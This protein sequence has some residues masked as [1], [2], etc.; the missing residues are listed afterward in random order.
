MTNIQS[1][2]ERIH[3][4]NLGQT[5]ALLL[6]FF[7]LTY[8]VYSAD[9]EPIS[10]PE[11]VSVGLYLIDVYDISFPENQIKLDFYMWFRYRGE[12]NNPLSTVE[13]VN[14]KEV[15]ISGET[16]EPYTDTQYRS[17][18]LKVVLKKQWNVRAF[19]FDRHVIHLYVED[20]ENEASSLVYI[21]DLRYSK[22]D[23][24]IDIPGWKLSEFSIA[25]RPHIWQTTYGDPSLGDSEYADYSRLTCSFV[26]SRKDRGLSMF[27][28][29]FMGLF[30]AIGISFLTFT[31]HPK[32]VDPRF[33]LSVGAI[34]AS[35]TNLYVVND[36]LPETTNITFVGSAHLI[37][38]AFILACITISARSLYL[39]NA[40]K[41]DEYRSLDRMSLIF[42]P[43][44]YISLMV[45]MFVAMVLL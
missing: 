24:D 21:P 44:A 18:K 27:L 13:I 9:D 37:T 33:G 26:L 34:F 28:N 42:L 20:D 2:N 43:I 12:Q 10:P 4:S 40:G 30:L 45:V 25:C 23:P 16:N 14:S 41:V 31:I 6:F 8:K 29:C 39:A 1:A 15:T 32:E 36:L 5:L 35:F 7:C 11:S 38:F 19:P 3:L 17:A 22:C